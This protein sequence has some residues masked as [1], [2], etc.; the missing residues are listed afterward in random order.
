MKK[1]QSKGM[2]KAGCIYLEYLEMDEVTGS[3]N[4]KI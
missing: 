3:C 1:E 4:V 2:L